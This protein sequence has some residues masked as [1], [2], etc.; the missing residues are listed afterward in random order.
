VSLVSKPRAIKSVSRNAVCQTAAYPYNLCKAY[1]TRGA[2][3]LFATHCSKL[4]QRGVSRN[5]FV[6]VPEEKLSFQ[7]CLHNVKF[8]SPDERI[9]FAAVRRIYFGN[10]TV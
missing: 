10:N 8:A 9:H 6:R 3:W 1:A 5:V 4:S 2:L 7:S